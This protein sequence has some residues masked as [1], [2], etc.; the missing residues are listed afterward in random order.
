[1]KILRTLR[2]AI[3]YLRSRMIEGYWDEPFNGQKF[4]HLIFKDLLEN[5]HFSI[6]IET[7]TYRGATTNFFSKNVMDVISIEIN[8]YFYGYAKSRF[9][10][11]PRVRLYHGDSSA[12]LASILETR[13]SAGTSCF[14]YLDAHWLKRL[15]LMDEVRLIFERLSEAIVMIDDF[16]VPDDPGY[17]FDDYGPGRQLDLDYLSAAIEKFSLSIFFPVCRSDRETG[18][19]RGCVV[20]ARDSTADRIR[21]LTTLREHLPFEKR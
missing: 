17:G 18:A 3:A 13:L 20:L 11:A 2:G 16:Q 6:V 5:F 7:G 19:K 14:C 8:D 1:M 21:H 15:P 9:L 4:R 12:L 10:L